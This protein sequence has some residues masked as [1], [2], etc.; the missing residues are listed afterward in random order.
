LWQAT[1]FWKLNIST[2]KHSLW[3]KLSGSLDLSMG[4]ILGLN[5]IIWLFGKYLKL[6]RRFSKT[7]ITQLQRPIGTKTLLVSLGPTY[8]QNMSSKAFYQLVTLGGS[9]S[10]VIMMDIRKGWCSFDL[11]LWTSLVLGEAKNELRKLRSMLYNPGQTI[12]SCESFL[13]DIIDIESIILF[14]SIDYFDFQ[15]KIKSSS[16]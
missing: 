10:L 16:N 1:V 4:K 8:A 13:P 3:L 2:K 15:H 9:P 12:S 5:P 6:C 7:V 11:L 14:E